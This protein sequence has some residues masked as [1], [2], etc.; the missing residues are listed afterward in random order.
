[1][2]HSNPNQKKL[3]AFLFTLFIFCCFLLVGHAVSAYDSQCCPEFT[4]ISDGGFGDPQNN[5]A[6]S[7]AEFK[8]DIYIGTGRNV[9]YMVA[10]AMKRQGAFPAN[11]TLSFLTHPAGSPPPSLY[12]PNETPPSPAD[13]ILWSHDMRAEIWRYHEGTWTQ[14]HQ[15]STFVNPLDGYTYPEGVGYRIMTPFTD[16]NGTEALYAGVGFGFGRVLVIRSTDGITWAPVNTSGIPSRDTRAMTTHNG[17]LYVGTGDG[18][19]ASACPS[20]STDTWEKVAGFQVASLKSFNGYLYAGTGNPGG[21]SE[22]DGFEVWR[23]SIASPEGPDDWVRVVSGGAGDAWNVLAASM[24]DYHGDLF[25]GSMNLPF[26]TGTEGLKGFD[27]IRVDTG[28][29]W[30][31]IVGN[32]HPKIPTDPRG[33][34]LSGWPS[35]FANPF[36]LYDW[37]L[38]TYRGNLYLGTFDIF[39]FARYIREVPGGEEML[40]DALS[41]RSGNDTGSTLPQNGTIGAF[42]AGLGEIN[43]TTYGDGENIVPIIEFLAWDFGGADLWSSPDGVLWVPVELN[44]FDDPDNYGF[45]TMLTTPDGIMI[46]TANPFNG[47]QVWVGT[48][49]ESPPD[50]VSNLHNTTY[51]QDQIT[52]NWTD[53]SSDNFSH[54]IVCLD[55][56]FMENVSKGV[57]TFTATGLDPDREYTIGTRTVS[58]GGLVNAT[59]VTYTARTAPVNRAWK[60]RSNLW[61]SGVYDDGGTRPEGALLWSYSTGDDVDSSPAVVDGVIYIGEYALDA[62]TG[63]VLWRFRPHDIIE[64]SPAVANGTVYVGCEDGNLYALDAD[65]GGVLWN[66]TTGAGV[67]SSPAVADGTVYFGSKDHNV[68]A[69]D[70][71]TGDLVWNFTTGGPVYSSPAVVDGVVYIGNCDHNVYAVDAET[72]DLVWNYTTGG[73]V[74]SSPAVV[75]GHVY[76]G[77]FDGLLYVLHADTGEFFWS[78]AAG[79]PVYSSPAVADGI[80]YFGCRNG[81]LYALNTE[82]PGYRWSYYAGEGVDSSPAVANGVV[83]FTSTDY[84]G[85]SGLY[86]LDA[87]TGELFWKYNVTRSGLKSSPAVADAVVYFGSR[88]RGSIFAIG[89]DLGP[90]NLMLGKLAPAFHENATDMTSTLFYRNQG[91]GTAGEVMLTEYLPPSVEFVSGTNYPVY[92]DTARTVTWGLGS[93]IFQASGSRSLTVRIPSSV[94]YGTVLTNTANITTTTPESRYDDNT[95]SANTTVR[96]LWLPPD[97]SVT[98]SVPG[99][100]GEICVDWRDETTFSYN[101]T[102]CPPETPVSIRIHLDDGGP[103]ITAPM[104]GGPQYWYYTTSFYPRHGAA[105]VT[106]ETPGCIITGITFDI[107]IDPA[108]YVYDTVSGNR[109]AG[110]EVWLQWPDE[111][112][113]WVNVPTGRSSPPMEPDVNPLTTNAAGQFQWEVEEGSY[114]VYAEMDGYAPAATTMVN[115]PPQFPDLAIGLDPATGNIWVSS[116]PTGAVICLDGSDTGFVTSHE[117]AG[118]SPGQHEVA[119]RLAG[120]RDYNETVTVTAG[121]TVTIQGTLIPLSPASV[122]DLHNTTCQPDSITWAWTD[123]DPA[124]FDHVMVY[125]DGVFR[126]N[127]TKGVQTFTASLL[128]PATS[129]EIG[130]RTAGATGLVNATW[131][132]HTAMTAPSHGGPVF[133]VLLPH[134]WNLF[135]TPVLLEQGYSQFPQIFTGTEQEKILIVLGWDGSV[136][137][138][139]APGT[140]VKPL[141]AFFVRVSEGEVANGTIVPSVIVSGPPARQVSTGVNLIGLAP[142]YDPETESFQE[143]PLTQALSSIEYVHDLRGYLIVISPGLNQPGWSYAQ[144]GPVHDMIPFRGYW[145]IME[146]GPDTLYGFS[147]TPITN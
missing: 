138:I 20:T 39:S 127:V 108:G 93:L 63:E 53:P 85:D 36:N 49:P 140:D 144:G 50:S 105:T 118:V 101:Q 17:K 103:D 67:Q 62:K 96:R 116:T 14:V 104:T 113:N 129:Y 114:R 86:A 134:G 59:W 5:Y 112:G 102:I 28:D 109:I 135:S 132:N 61:N 141:D 71:D 57:R 115:A 88:D 56:V 23:S 10:L 126:A 41:S 27:L 82:I 107:R 106:Y 42:L 78:Y 4:M 58:T 33:P 21:P 64:S 146:N 124:G 130:T 136:W 131:V 122:T 68:Y 38:E 128:T 66:Y 89:P 29:S 35:G 8:G 72:G 22:T 44:G 147:T 34:P 12:N 31:L 94:P 45:R 83:Y 99:P 90:A 92:N 120:Y 19:Y 47:C 15:A 37:S 139:P 133:N 142:A 11:L 79:A 18:I 48:T 110:A 43:Q 7:M 65:T 60:F 51:L 84:P 77:S 97:V 16:T 6:W 13:V 111:E 52:W 143:M 95:A 3:N 40:L 87:L 32:Y 119:L 80:V 54:V 98:P 24:Q 100:W 9:P 25:V 137:Y 121:H 145:V 117:L 26:G 30:D 1:M 75:D 74:Y 125:I 70:A 55:G 123:P 81:Y 2:L 76:I 46:G 69:L 73:M 91:T